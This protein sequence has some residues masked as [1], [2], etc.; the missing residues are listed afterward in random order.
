MIMIKREM[1]TSARSSIC[2]RA[3]LRHVRRDSVQHS[4]YLETEKSGENLT[5]LAM[6]RN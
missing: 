6:K 1:T 4:R 5:V 2:D 3:R